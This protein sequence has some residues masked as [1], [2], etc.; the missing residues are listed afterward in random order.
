VR[1]EEFAAKRAQALP[2]KLQAS[3][4]QLAAGR[5]TCQVNIVDENGRKFGFARTEIVV[6]PTQTTV[7]PAAD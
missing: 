3:L 2:I 6:L 5:Y 1:L 4:S 7:K